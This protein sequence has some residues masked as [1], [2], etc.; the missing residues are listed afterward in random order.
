MAHTDT[1][2]PELTP[3]PF[4]EDEEFMYSPGV[5]DDTANLAVL[6]VCARYFKD[7]FKGGK[8]GVLFVANS[9][10]EGLGNLKGTRQIMADYGERVK[11]FISFD[12]QDDSG[13]SI[14]VGSRR[15]RVA[16]ET[17]GGHSFRDFGN[18][19]AIAVLARLI[20]RLYAIKVP[21]EGKT[22]YNVGTVSGGTSFPRS[23]TLNP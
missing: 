2:F 22:T 4:S 23:I 13:V 14:A 9:C 16:V 5:T 10:E 18:R 12:S 3:L 17:E 15:Y 8:D 6:M 11:E 7:N 21:A 1:V 19:S 20:D